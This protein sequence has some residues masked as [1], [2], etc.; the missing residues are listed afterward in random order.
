MI[1]RYRKAIVA[2]GTAGLIAVEQFIP[3]SDRVH[4]WIEVVLAVLGAIG[5]YW[6]ENDP[7]PPKQVPSDGS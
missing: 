3:L 7:M 5:V 4:G 1:G 2:V 6:V